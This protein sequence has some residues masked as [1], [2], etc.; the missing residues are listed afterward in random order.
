[1]GRPHNP[2]RPRMMAGAAISG[3]TIIAI[4]AYLRHIF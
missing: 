1:M 3:L 4:A 2:R